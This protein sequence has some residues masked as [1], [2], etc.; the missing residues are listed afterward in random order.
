MEQNQ[1]EKN[2]SLVISEIASLAPDDSAGRASLVA[3]LSG[4]VWRWAALWFSQSQ[5]ENATVEIMKCVR[6][7]AGKFSGLQEGCAAYLFKSVREE[8]RRAN[9]ANSDFEAAVIPLPENR[10]RMLRQLLRHAGEYG[11]D[12]R[13]AE[14]MRSFA[15]IYGISG[16]EIAGLLR[17]DFQSCTV[18]EWTL[19]DGQE[20][21]LFE[22]ALIT[23]SGGFLAPEEILIRR[24]S[25]ADILSRIDR[26]FLL[27]QRR[28]RLYLSALITREV[29]CALRTSDEE[30]ISLIKDRAFAQTESAENLIALFM[31][32][33]SI[34]AQQE[35]AAWFGKSK[36]EASRAMRNF[37][38]KLSTLW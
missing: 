34:P 17:E 14:T 33:G 18:S 10:R 19:H 1:I 24:E 9:K 27:E 31:K 20:I 22:S 25:I 5:L 21:S 36:S 26:A 23:P 37:R 2:I 15:R 12:L 38:K 3:K 32:D 30:I 13:H 16:D 6:L 8:I 29:L 35:V 4:A 11:K 7:C 28:V